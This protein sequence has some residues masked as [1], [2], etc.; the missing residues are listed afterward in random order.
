M[1]T[2]T[3]R[4]RWLLQRRAAKANTAATRALP[5]SSLFSSRKQ[6]ILLIMLSSIARSVSRPVSR[7]A[8]RSGK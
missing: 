5:L 3:T 4:W 8:V 6:S 7:T 2:A 1:G